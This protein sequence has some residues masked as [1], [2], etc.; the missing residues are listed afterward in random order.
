MDYDK[1]IFTGNLGRD[2]EMRYTPGGS[3]VTA[4]PVATNRQYKNSE[5]KEIQETTWRRVEVWGR[6]A[7]VCNK[8]LKKGS[9]VFIEGRLKPDPETG[10]PKIYKRK[11]GEPGASFEVSASR[12]IFLDS[13][14]DED[15]DDIPF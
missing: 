15:G 8:Y 11:D 5:D 7:E 6:L 13:R 4:F 12:V 14:K 9:R 2:P 3:K 10:G 1:L